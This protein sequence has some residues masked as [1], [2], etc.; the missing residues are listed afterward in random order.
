MFG[1]KNQKYMRYWGKINRFRAIFT[2][3]KDKRKIIFQ[4]IN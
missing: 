1:L 3:I 4:K 2:E